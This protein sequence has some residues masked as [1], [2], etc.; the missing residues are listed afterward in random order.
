MAKT[1]YNRA[2]FRFAA[3]HDREVRFRYAKGEKQAQIEERV[4][5]PVSVKNGLVVGLDS[6][7]EDYRSYRLDRVLGEVTIVTL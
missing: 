6:D 2:V 4:V 3:K 5:T 1:D 7:R